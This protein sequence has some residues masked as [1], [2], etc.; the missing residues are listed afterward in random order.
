MSHTVTNYVG[1]I[2]LTTNLING[3]IYVGMHRV[4]NNQK[5]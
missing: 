1:Y 5:R 4:K 3:K 2:Y